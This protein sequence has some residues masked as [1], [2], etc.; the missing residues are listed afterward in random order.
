MNEKKAKNFEMDVALHNRLAEF[1]KNNGHTFRWVIEQAIE[2]W[3]DENEVLREK[4]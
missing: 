2:K 4:L 1:C 3:L